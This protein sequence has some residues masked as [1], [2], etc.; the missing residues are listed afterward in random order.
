MTEKKE[1][2]GKDEKQENF[3]DLE[4]KYLRALADYQNLIKQTAREKGEFVKYANEGLLIDLLPV[5]DHLK[6]SLD[7]AN[8]TDKWLEGVK[9]VLG[10]F[11]KVLSEAGVLAIETNGQP[12][13]HNLMEAVANEDTDE[14][15][16]DGLVAKELKAGYTLN[17]KVVI[18]ARVTVFK[19]KA[20]S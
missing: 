3:K 17:G 14:E 12:F 4:A 13:D 7:H 19:L 18:P 9:H 10:Q 5:Y 1:K 11:K 20:E 2:H 8:A 6:M 15:S 16:Q